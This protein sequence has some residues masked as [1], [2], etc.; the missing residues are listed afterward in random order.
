MVKEDLIK[1]E[2]EELEKDADQKMCGSRQVGFWFPFQARVGFFSG[3]P[4]V[5]HKLYSLKDAFIKIEGSKIV[6]D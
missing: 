4:R 3:R 5:G 6:L 1:I 2:E